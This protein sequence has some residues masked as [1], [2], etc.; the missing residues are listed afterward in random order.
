MPLCEVSKNETDCLLKQ[1]WNVQVTLTKG[2]P[3]ILF[4]KSCIIYR[5]PIDKTVLHT[6]IHE[7]I[8]NLHIKGKQSNFSSYLKNVKCFLFFF[9]LFVCISI[10]KLIRVKVTFYLFILICCQSKFIG[11]FYFLCFNDATCASAVISFSV[12]RKWIEKKRKE[13]NQCTVKRN[14]VHF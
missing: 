3:K 7:K 1:K 2:I 5:V 12:K 9:L 11:H 6:Y 14:P 4:C 13:K 10:W 8:K